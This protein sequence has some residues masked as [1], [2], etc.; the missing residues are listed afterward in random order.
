VVEERDW[1]AAADMVIIPKRERK[2]NKKVI[3][4]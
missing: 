2:V 4:K 3:K 1:A